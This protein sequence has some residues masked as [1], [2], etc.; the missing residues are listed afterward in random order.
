MPSYFLTHVGKDLSSLSTQIR[1]HG[2]L[3]PIR[4]TNQKLKE[5]DSRGLSIFTSFF[6]YP[7]HNQLYD[8][9]IG[10]IHQLGNIISTP[11][12]YEKVV[13]AISLIESI[14][15]PKDG[16]KAMGQTRLKLVISKLVTNQNEQKVLVKITHVLY[17][18]RDRYLHNYRKLPIDITHLMFFLNFERVFILK[19]IKLN[20]TL[21]S[22][23][24]VHNY[25][26]LKS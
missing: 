26:G 20:I 7:K 22:I 17:N 21:N 2:A 8:E 18:I 10:L 12:N 1:N 25:F 16:G 15:V 19:L 13:K 9:I 11:D 14:L 23:E 3:A 5:L 24:E 6:Q 4:L